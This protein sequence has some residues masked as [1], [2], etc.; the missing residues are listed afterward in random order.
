MHPTRGTGAAPPAPAAAGAPPPRRPAAGRLQTRPPPPL[1]PQRP[2]CGHAGGPTWRASALH[3]NVARWSPAA[4]CR[5]CAL[6]RP[7]VVV[8]PGALVHGPPAGVQVSR[9]EAQ[10]LLIDERVSGLE[11]GY[12]PDVAGASS[13]QTN[14]L[15]HHRGPGSTSRF[16]LKGPAVPRRSREA[17]TALEK[18]QQQRHAR[19]LTTTAIDLPPLGR[20]WA[21]LLASPPIQ[22]R[23]QHWKTR[24]PVQLATTR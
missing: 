4:V 13:D 20:P 22:R 10:G 9:E 23:R 19:Y 2:R 14:Q 6:Y 1:P 5:W 16:P 3:R 15:T 17:G 7:L 24:R 18:L 8:L 21:A 11:L 12:V